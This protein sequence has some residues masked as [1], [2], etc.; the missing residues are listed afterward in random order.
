MNVRFYTY[1]VLE[2]GMHFF[3]INLCKGSKSFG[4]RSNR[5]LLANLNVNS[6]QGYCKF[7]VGFLFGLF[8]V[9]F[10]YIVLLYLPSI[11]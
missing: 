1:Y 7:W 9:P 5:V 3:W 11:C 8:N 2:N 10:L 4:S 6:S